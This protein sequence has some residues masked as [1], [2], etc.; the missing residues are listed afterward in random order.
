M[1]AQCIRSSV[2]GKTD[3]I[4]NLDELKER[5]IEHNWEDTKSMHQHALLV[6]VRAFAKLEGL[7]CKVL[8]D[9]LVQLLW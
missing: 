7:V 3:I 4:V 6:K 5:S 1:Y 2:I 9:K 8:T